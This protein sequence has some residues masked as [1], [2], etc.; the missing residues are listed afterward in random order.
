MVWEDSSGEV[1]LEMPQSGVQSGA[2]CCWQQSCGL[3]EGLATSQALFQQGPLLFSELGVAS[4]GWNGEW[5][6]CP[7]ISHLPLR[8]GEHNAQALWPSSR[9]LF[10]CLYPSRLSFCLSQTT[11]QLLPYVF[12]PL[13]KTAKAPRWEV[14]SQLKFN[15]NN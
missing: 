7:V 13:Q 9:E 3:A 11:T 2:S 8:Q 12:F 14:A 15:Q 5:P 6:P 4:P 10:S 1:T